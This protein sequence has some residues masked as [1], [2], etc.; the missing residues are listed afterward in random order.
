MV[1]CAFK[2]V[3]STVR[4]ENGFSLI[5]VALALII[6]SMIMVPVFVY[7]HAQAQGKLISDTRG[8]FSRIENALNQYFSAGHGAYPCPASL[9]IGE[10][11]A[12]YGVSYPTPA[13]DDLSTIRE[14][15]TPEWDDTG[16]EGVCKTSSVD[17]TAVLIG[18]VPFDTI[19][20]TQHETLDVWG[21][22]IIYAVTYEQTKSTTFG[23]N[24]GQ[25]EIWAY[26]DDDTDT[27][28]PGIPQDI[29][30]ASDMTDFLLLSTGEN[31]AGAYTAEGVLTS[32]CPILTNNIESENCDFDNTFFLDVNPD[33]PDEGSRNYGNQLAYYDDLTRYQGSVPETIWFPHPDQPDHVMTLST[34]VGIG[35]NTPQETL[36]VNG[37]IRA[38]GAVKTDTICGPTDTNCF[39]PRFVTEN[40]PC[41][42]NINSSGFPAVVLEM[43]SNTLRCAGGLNN[44]GSEIG[45]SSTFS[46]SNNFS[47]TTCTGQ[48]VQAGFDA[49][50]EPICVDQ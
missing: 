35:T 22:K 32:A 17:G 9:I 37:N 4:E 23:T 50:G 2:R 21:N 45:N 10:G 47:T 33:N 26:V 6:I 31:A 28:T 39:N 25:I 5:E 43:T 16:N 36:D 41:I 7:Y 20:L 3:K 11:N 34:R 49:S 46:F 8:R 38:D 13:C 44:D 48:R 42:G 12:D 29:T 30:S 18:A 14:C 1:F 27:S 19:G 40:N 15:T 24:P